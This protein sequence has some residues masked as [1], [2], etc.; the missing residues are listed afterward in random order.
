[1]FFYYIFYH[2]NYMIFR[3]E[4]APPGLERSVSSPG[5]AFRSLLLWHKSNDFI[6][7]LQKIFHFF[8][9]HL[10]FFVSLLFD[11]NKLAQ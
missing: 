7:I 1:M 5:G 9:F 2:F 4:K 6:L 3:H 10:I 8:Y 11:T